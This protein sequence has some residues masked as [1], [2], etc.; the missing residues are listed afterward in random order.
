M[1]LVPRKKNVTFMESVVCV[2]HGEAVLRS[3]RERSRLG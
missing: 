1:R 3:G 2:I